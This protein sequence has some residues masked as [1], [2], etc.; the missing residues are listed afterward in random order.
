M[1][2]I[3]DPRFKWNWMYLSVNQ[4]IT[5]DNIRDTINDPRFKWNWI[6]LSDNNMSKGRD[7]HIINELK[8]IGCLNEINL[9]DNLLP[10]VIL[11]IIINYL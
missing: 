8:F 6:F 5:F 4:N 7:T 1:D 3:D 10:N 11:N 9:Y 2:K